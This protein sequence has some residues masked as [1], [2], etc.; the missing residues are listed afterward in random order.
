[1]FHTDFHNVELLFFI[2]KMICQIMHVL[3]GGVEAL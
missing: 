1:M 2:L 3:S